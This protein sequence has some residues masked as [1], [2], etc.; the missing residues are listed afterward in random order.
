MIVAHRVQMR[1]VARNAL[2]LCGSA[3]REGE[4]YVVPPTAKSCR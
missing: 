2:R 1:R 3:R 4:K